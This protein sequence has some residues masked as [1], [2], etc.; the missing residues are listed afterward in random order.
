MTIEPAALV[1]GWAK[2]VVGG[3]D[4]SLTLSVDVTNTGTRR[5]SEVVQVYVEQPGDDP[6]RPIRQLAAFQR[7]DVEPG[8]TEQADIVVPTRAF[9][10]W[11]TDGWYV[12]AGEH[13]ILVGRSSRSLALAGSLDVPVAT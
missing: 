11:G 4:S 10:R 6:T 1:G 13:R 8:A 9:R 7:V 12:P 3:P 2:G 5:G